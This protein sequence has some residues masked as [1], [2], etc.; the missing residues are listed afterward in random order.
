MGSKLTAY[1]IGL[2]IIGL[3]TLLLMVVVVWQ[4]GDYKHDNK[5]N[6][7]ASGIA[8]TLNSYIDNNQSVPSNLAQAGVNDPPSGI[9]Y[10]KLSSDSYKFC[11]DYRSSANGFSSSAVTEQ[12]L[13]LSTGFGASNYTATQGPTL[14]ILPYYHKGENCQTI[15]PPIYT[16]NSSSTD[17]YSKCNSIVDNTAYFNCVNQLQSQTGSPQATLQ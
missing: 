9:T 17:P 5:L 15:K 4:A 13:S 6:Q 16:N 10:T 12:L 11:V 1:K 14:S 2:G 8:D 3:F 7:Q